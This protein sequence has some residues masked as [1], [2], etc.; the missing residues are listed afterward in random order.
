MGAIP[1]SE[2]GKIDREAVRR[3]VVLLAYS[4]TGSVAH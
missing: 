2:R 1:R 3:E 4:R